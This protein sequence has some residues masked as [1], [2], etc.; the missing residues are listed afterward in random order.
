MLGGK[1]VIVGADLPMRV[2]IR[3]FGIYKNSGMIVGH[4]LV[5]GRDAL[6]DYVHTRI[7]SNAVSPWDR[8]APIRGGNFTVVV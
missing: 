3:I 8:V 6:Y 5:S 2:R 1:L 7:R 4:Q